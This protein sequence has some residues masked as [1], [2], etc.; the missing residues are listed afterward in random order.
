MRLVGRVNVIVKRHKFPAYKQ[1]RIFFGGQAWSK[2]PREI[3]PE[4][5]VDWMR[6]GKGTFLLRMLFSY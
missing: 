5:F 1:A 3:K 2:L 4:S 6:N